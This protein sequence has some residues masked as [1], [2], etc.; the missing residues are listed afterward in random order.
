MPENLNRRLGQTSGH[1]LRN[2]LMNG[3]RWASFLFALALWQSRKQVS[4]ARAPG[5]TKNGIVM[6]RSEREP[7]PNY[8]GRCCE[9]AVDAYTVEDAIFWH[10]EIINELAVQIHEAQ[11]KLWPESAKATV[12]RALDE[13]QREHVRA[14][15]RLSGVMQRNEQLIWQPGGA[16]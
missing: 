11:L 9:Q 6:Q 5:E 12:I 13:R 4:P 3:E 15:N 1:S 8:L 14:V 10:C 7:A 2:W 16:N